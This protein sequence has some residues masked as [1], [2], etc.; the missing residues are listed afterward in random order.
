MLVDGL[1][2]VNSIFSS[3]HPHIEQETWE[4]P[5]IGHVATVSSTLPVNN[6]FGIY[7]LL[8]RHDGSRP[9]Q[10]YALRSRTLLLQ[11]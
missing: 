11:K 5:T 4:K 7:R 2:L 8:L 6:W 1:S 9:E 10:M 3:A